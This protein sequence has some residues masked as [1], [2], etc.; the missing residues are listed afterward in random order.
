MDVGFT[1]TVTVYVHVHVHYHG[2]CPATL[3]QCC[4]APVTP[5]LPPSEGLTHHNIEECHSM[6]ESSYWQQSPLPFHC[7]AYT[8]PVVHCR[9]WRVTA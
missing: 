1:V 7:A 5:W 8:G 2:V 6:V 9:L 3:A 4:L